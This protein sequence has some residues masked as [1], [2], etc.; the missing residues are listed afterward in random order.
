MFNLFIK[1][2]AFTLLVTGCNACSITEKF[3]GNNQS[4]QS[5]EEQEAAPESEPIP[6]N[7]QHS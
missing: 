5:Q 7:P 1:L 6:V 2:L 4:E 3:F